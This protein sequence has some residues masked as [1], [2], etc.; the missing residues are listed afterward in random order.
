[1]FTIWDK[2]LPSIHEPERSEPCNSIDSVRRPES[3]HS[4]GGSRHATQL[5]SHW[6][7][8][9]LGADERENWIT[10]LCKGL[11]CLANTIGK[12]MI[13]VGSGSARPAWTRRSSE[14][15]C[16]GYCVMRLASPASQCLAYYRD[17]P[18]VKR[19]AYFVTVGACT[20][21]H[22]QS[23]VHTCIT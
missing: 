2:A 8:T 18:D 9:L 5:L 7:F 21:A 15:N 23:H 16:L 6:R 11:P 10:L 17:V 4:T 1:M 14:H 13:G 22:T 20:H 19:G 3:R 12:H